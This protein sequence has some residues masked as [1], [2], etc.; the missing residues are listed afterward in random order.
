MYGLDEKAKKIVEM[1]NADRKIILKG[2]T[3]CGKSTL[4]LE[5]YRF[6]VESLKIPSDRILILLLNRTQSLDWRKKTV[7]KSSGAVWR[8]SYYGFIQSEIRTYYPIVLENCSEIVNKQIKPTFL[9]FE[10]AQFLVSKVIDKHRERRGLFAG[11]TSFTDRI[12]IDLTANLVKAATSDIP[13]HEIGERLYSALEL[14][15]ETKRQVFRDADGI[16]SAY[17]KK[18]LE[19]GIFD[20]GMAVEVYNRYLFTDERY[21]EHLFRRVQHVFADNIEE[22]VPTEVDF[23]YSLL[24]NVKS[25][26]LGYNFEG[27]YGEAFGGNH[28]YMKQ[29]LINGCETIEMGKSYTCSSFM[30]EFSEM[31]FDSIENGKRGRVSEGANIEKTPPYELRSEMLEAAAERVCALISS[32]GYKPSDI[33]IL[34]THAD[35]VSEYVIE[36]ILQ[37][38]GIKLKN[39]SRKSRVVDNP[40]TQA[41]ITLAQLCHPDYG[42]HPNRDDVKALIRLLLKI[43]PVR[44]SLLAGEVCSRKPFAEFPDVEFPGLV[45]RIGYHNV[46]KYEKIRDWIKLYKA[47][48]VPLPINEFFQKVF[49]EILISKD[50]DVLDSDILQAK[51]L[52]DSARTFADVVSR[53]NMNASREFLA[54]VRRG[55]KSAESIFE[56]EE[57]L[58]GDFVLLSTPV[59]YLASSLS[60]KV[61]IL[62]SLS[63]RNW[64]PRSV[65]EL[66]NAH[67]LTKTWEKGDIYTEEMEERNQKRYLALLT[68]ALLKRCG[69]KLITFESNLSANGY[70]NDGDLSEYFDSILT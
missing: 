2:P 20:F 10:S 67:V 50:V 47:Q 28:E 11:V 56:I 41:L 30:S 15:D 66:S 1:P 70:E 17:R 58:G 40:F 6:M 60:N 48:A 45:E 33:A 54:M 63:S 23:I 18:C 57:R 35:P 12:A 13:C 16:L 22:C 69:E 37:R 3:G 4:L 14:K 8:T 36:K 53:F 61:I 7:L 44:S 43:D 59:A 52:I 26:M 55:I 46:E 42:E 31:L 65:K 62:T 34:S 51:N 38:Q 27:G 19:L 68:R 5:R 24:P 32:N 9:T 21:R 39:L 29:K 49:L 64:T 25:C